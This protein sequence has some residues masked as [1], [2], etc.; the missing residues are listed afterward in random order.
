MLCWLNSEIITSLVPKV[1]INSQF[2]I[3]SDIQPAPS[4]ARSQVLMRGEKMFPNVVKYF[5]ENIIRTW[6]TMVTGCENIP[7]STNAKIYS[8]RYYN[9][10]EPTLTLCIS[11]NRYC[12]N[13]NRRHQRNNIMFVIDIM[14][15]CFTQKCHYDFCSGYQSPIIGLPP[16]IFF[17]TR[18]DRENIG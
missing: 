9:N 7:V 4:P 13:V 15:F 11:S 5:S 16:E 18:S 1:D 12:L 3:H 6:P 17:S 2:S 14:N 10:T 8:I